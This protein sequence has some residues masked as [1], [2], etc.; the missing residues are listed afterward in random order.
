MS[1]KLREQVLGINL[2]HRMALRQ[3]LI[4]EGVFPVGI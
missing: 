4:D 2:P 3:M 1:T